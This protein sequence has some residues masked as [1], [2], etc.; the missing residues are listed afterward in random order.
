[1][2]KVKKLLETITD[3]RTYKMAIRRTIGGCD[4]C[5]PHRGCNGWWNT[6]PVEM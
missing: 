5:P 2:K 4:Y 1:M 3:S 6:K